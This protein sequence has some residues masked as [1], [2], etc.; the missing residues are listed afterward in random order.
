MCCVWGDDHG[1]VWFAFVWLF[2]TVHFQ[3]RRDR[4]FIFYFCVSHGKPREETRLSMRPGTTSECWLCSTLS[5]CST[6][7]ARVVADEAKTA[8]GTFQS[9]LK[10][11]RFRRHRKWLFIPDARSIANPFWALAS[12]KTG[13]LCTAAPWFYQVL[14]VKGNVKGQYFPSF[15]HNKTSSQSSEMR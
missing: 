10:V 6:P 14:Y 5:G 1:K 7:A 15:Q 11:F 2:S 13:F 12:V 4:V 9:Q 3:M 8:A